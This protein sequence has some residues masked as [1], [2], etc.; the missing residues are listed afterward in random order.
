M[1]VQ[2]VGYYRCIGMLCV[3]KKYAHVKAEEAQ[4]NDRPA[5][6]RRVGEPFDAVDLSARSRLQEMGKRRDRLARQ[7]RALREAQAADPESVIS[8]EL[9]DVQATERFGFKKQEAEASGSGRE[10]ASRPS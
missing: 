5:W 4:V 8:T 2:G 6:L 10:A 9:E 1:V 7:L 3:F